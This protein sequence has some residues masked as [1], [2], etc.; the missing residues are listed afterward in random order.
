MNC[1]TC[2]DHLDSYLSR[3]LPPEIS[4]EVE[5]HLGKCESCA[6]AYRL[7]LLAGM[8]IENEKEKVSN[9]F[10]KTRIMA[11]IENIETAPQAAP[12][13]SRVLRPVYITAALAA[14]L[15]YGIVAGN[16]LHPSGKRSAI[17]VELAMI[18][19]AAIESVELLSNE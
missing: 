4:S 2:Q 6:A 8:V 3:N 10:L 5:S 13:F 11:A 12:E 14:A 16:I 7:M 18:N 17:P 9:P 19:D 1:K 15:L